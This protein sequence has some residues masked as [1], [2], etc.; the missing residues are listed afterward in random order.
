MGKEKNEEEMFY[1]PVARLFRDLEKVSRKRPKF[2]DH[3]VSSRVEF[4]KAVRS[5]IDEGIERLEK[6]TPSK[7]RRKATKIKVE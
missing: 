6:K 1:C 2:L 7:A 3:L 5:L 4:L